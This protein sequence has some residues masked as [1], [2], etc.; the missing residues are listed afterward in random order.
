MRQ[1]IPYI[2]TIWIWHSCI[3]AVQAFNI[4]T[5]PA[6]LFLN[7]SRGIFSHLLSMQ[8]C[9]QGNVIGIIW[10]LEETLSRMAKLR[11]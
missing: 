9:L 3:E 5:Y 1:H 4:Q 6:S 2:R 7:S 11:I 10:L 8:L